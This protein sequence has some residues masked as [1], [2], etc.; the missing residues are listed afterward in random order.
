MHDGITATLH[1]PRANGS[2]DDPLL[3]EA[4]RFV[5]ETRRASISAIQRKLKI[6]YN[7]AAR[8]VEEMELLNIVGPMK[9]DGSREVLS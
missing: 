9:G 1:I 7:R 6:G 2:G 5:R 3:K 8:L 4:I